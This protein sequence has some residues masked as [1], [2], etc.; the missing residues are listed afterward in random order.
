ITVLPG[1]TVR[2]VHL[3]IRPKDPGSPAIIGSVW[4]DSESAQVV[5]FE[6]TFTGSSYRDATVEDITVA[7][8]HGLWDG[9]FWLP[10]RQELEIRRRTPL[11]DLPA[12][13]IIRAEWNIENYRFNSGL[14]DSIF[15]GIQVAIRPLDDLASYGWT[16]PI[17]TALRREIG[18][19]PA[20]LEDVRME[21]GR[22]GVQANLSGLA[23]TRIGIGGISDLVHVNRVEGLALGAGGVFRP[24]DDFSATGWLGYGLSDRRWKWL[25]ELEAEIPMGRLAVL[26][27]RRIRD[28][29]DVPTA[30]GALNSIGAQ[31]FGF[32]FGDYYL[33]EAVLLKLSNA[34]YGRFW[35]VWLGRIN[36][37]SVETSTESMRGVNRL[38]PLL[39]T[40]SSFWTVGLNF[41]KEWR[42]GIGGILAID[43]RA[44]AASDTMDLYRRGEL[45]VH[46]QAPVG[47]T[48]L[49]VDAVGGAGS[50]GMPAF[51]SFVLGGRG[52]LPGEE[53]RGFGGRAIAWSRLGWRFPVPF[54]SIGMG[55]FV[56]TGNRIQVT[57]YVS[58]GHSWFDVGGQ[59]WVPSP[60]ARWG[61]G[62]RVEL[63]QRL[64]WFD[65]G[66][67][68]VT[69]EWALS[70]D[71]NPVLWPIL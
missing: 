8:D 63:L 5:R 34:G 44:E 32:D 25:L 61:S 55:S 40:G 27:E 18:A 15:R 54:P 49:V 57:P 4:L 28:I 35:E 17:E 16:E 38:N 47:G 65:L 30:S 69:K 14:A 46:L 1:L 13:G 39:G 62:I 64:V 68:W 20:S 70:A 52:T 33:R 51:R 56:S 50:E 43:L 58:V 12:R 53:Y 10:R 21:I 66:V 41:S 23:P 59:P 71:L 37:A 11:I 42:V 45:T 67:S 26:A 2:A 24:L 9:K 7:L 19:R 6:F 3:R 60:G 48:A 22:A 31:E 36:A 29:A